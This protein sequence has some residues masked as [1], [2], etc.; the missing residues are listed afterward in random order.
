MVRASGAFHD[1]DAGFIVPRCTSAE[2]IPRMLELCRQESVKL[3]IPTI[4]TELPAYAA[5]RA[6]FAAI[7]TTVC[8]SSEDT[9][10]IGKDKKATHEWLMA[11]NFPTVRQA[12]PEQVLSQPE[13]WKYPLIAKPTAGSS[14]IGVCRVRDAKEL[15]VVTAGGDYIVQTL[16]TGVEHT[17]DVFLNRR[18]QALC[19]VPRRRLETRAGEV[20]K[21]LTVRHPALQ[22]LASEIAERLPGGY[23]TLNVQIFADDERDTLQVIE[24]NTRFGGGYPLSHE[25]GAKF[26]NW[27]V[28]ETTGAD[29][30]SAF[31][32]WR[33]GLVMLRYD[34]AVFVSKED[35]GL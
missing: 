18:G 15:Q 5:H 8:I 35:A 17:V 21:G 30:S 28:Q 7:G 29:V 1:C 14:S 24:I 27:L 32:D 20:S 6:E 33:S 31:D 16:A 34:A 23:G 9:I 2:F 13:A 3:L 4:D 10:K 26:A 12:L 22:A 19:A 11:Q 25:A